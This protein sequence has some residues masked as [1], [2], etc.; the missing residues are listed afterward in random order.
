MVNDKQKIKRQEYEIIS[1]ILLIIRDTTLIG[2]TSLM[3]KANLSSKVADKYLTKLLKNNLIEI[4]RV[5]IKKSQSKH[6]FLLTDKGYY[7]LNKLIRF[8]KIYKELFE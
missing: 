5:E 2:I 6:Y 4:N 3:L 7:L 8:N 1:D